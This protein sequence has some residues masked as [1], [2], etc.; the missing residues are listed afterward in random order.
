MD[1]P[2]MKPGKMEEVRPEGAPE[3][4]KHSPHEP[5][6]LSGPAAAM[7]CFSRGQLRPKREMVLEH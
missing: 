3:Q 2:A 4:A 5:F 6:L 1:L 7:K